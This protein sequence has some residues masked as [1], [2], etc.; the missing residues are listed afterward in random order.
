M[1]LKFHANNLLVEAEAV[2]R[3]ISM[4]GSL[5]DTATL[6]PEQT[7]VSFVLTL[8]GWPLI[9]PILVKG[10]ARVVRIEP[11]KDASGFVMALQFVGPI[12]EIPGLKCQGS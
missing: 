4:G 5:L 1:Q 3:N 9:R 10:Q 6:I 8:R 2:T 7:R 11:A 12:I